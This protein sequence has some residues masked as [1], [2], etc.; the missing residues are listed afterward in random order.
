[1]KG[2]TPNADIRRGD[3]TATGFGGTPIQPLPTGHAF[4]NMGA[5]LYTHAR[6][7]ASPETQ[8][9]LEGVRGTSRR[10]TAT[11]KSGSPTPTRQARRGVD[12]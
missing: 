1:M 2:I 4:D 3:I 7:S 8:A 11:T 9:V 12:K 6:Q 10:V 5:A